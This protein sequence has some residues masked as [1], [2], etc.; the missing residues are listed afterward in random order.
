MSL[1]CLPHLLSLSTSGDQSFRPSVWL[2]ASLA[3]CPFV[4]LPTVSVSVFRSMSVFHYP[5]VSICLCLWQETDL[6]I[7]G[8]CRLLMSGCPLVAVHK[9]RYY[10][11]PDGLAL[12]PGP[13]VEALEYASGKKAD[14]IGKP[15]RSFFQ[16]ALDVLGVSAE[17][18]AMIGDVCICP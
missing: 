9:A 7:Y 10:K 11:R 2:S 6:T 15:E 5:S 4:C 18:T 14:V 1:P 13:F 12:G 16:S 3:V 17:E 8:N